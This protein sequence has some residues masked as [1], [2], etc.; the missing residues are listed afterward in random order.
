[1]PHAQSGQSLGGPLPCFWHANQWNNYSMDRP[2]A[3]RTLTGAVSPFVSSSRGHVLSPSCNQHS[4]RFWVIQIAFKIYGAHFPCAHPRAVSFLRS[5]HRSW[6]FQVIMKLDPKISNVACTSSV[7][8]GSF[9]C[10]FHL[11]GKCATSD[12]VLEARTAMSRKSGSNRG[13]PSNPAKQLLWNIDPGSQNPM[14]LQEVKLGTK[15]YLSPPATLG[16]QLWVYGRG[17]RRWRRDLTTI[18]EQGNSKSGL[19]RLLWYIYYIYSLRNAD[20][21]LYIYICVHIHSFFPI[22]KYIMGEKFAGSENL[23]LDKTFGVLAR[24]LCYA[25]LPQNPPVEPQRFREDRFLTAPPECQTP[26]H[27]PLVNFVSGGVSWVFDH[28]FWGCI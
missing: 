23:A 6:F 4:E 7:S 25:T 2:E 24:V 5:P 9:A 18:V 22:S 15:V 21:Q 16:S 27:F 26:S 12:Q 20:K 13:S 10:N 19:L 3:H 8:V 17:P 14:C 28:Q 11:L 1:M